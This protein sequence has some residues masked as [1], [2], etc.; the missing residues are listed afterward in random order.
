V[1]SGRLLQGQVIFSAPRQASIHLQG[2][3]TPALSCF[4]ALH[5][6]ASTSGIANLSCNDGSA[7]VVPFQA[8]GPLRGSG[9]SQGGQ[10]AF[11]L[12]YG[13]PPEMLATYLGVASEQLKPPS[14]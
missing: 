3:A 12:A 9:R 6:T 7:V 1:Y 14:P 5:F 2:S 4:G 11:S 13:L 10:P 8:L